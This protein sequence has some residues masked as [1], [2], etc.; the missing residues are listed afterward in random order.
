MAGEA[1]QPEPCTERCDEHYSL[2]RAGVV[3]HGSRIIT[4]A[5]AVWAA[6][7]T[8]GLLVVRFFWLLSGGS[9]RDQEDGEVVNEFFGTSGPL[10]ER[11][12]WRRRGWD[13]GAGRSGRRLPGAALRFGRPCDHAAIS[14]DSSSSMTCPRSSSSKEWWILLLRGSFVYPQ[15]KLCSRPSKFSRCRSWGWFLT[16]RCCASTGTWPTSL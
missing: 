14:S 11:W 8:V 13:G 15:C 3:R 9:G 4:I 7:G 10:G 5:F 1:K 16:A 6:A 2:S 12:G